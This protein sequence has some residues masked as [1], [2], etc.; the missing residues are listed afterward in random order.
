VK[1][2]GACKG[3]EDQERFFFPKAEIEYKEKAK[4]EMK[5]QTCKFLD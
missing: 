2:V 1:R 3:T 4:E 5:K